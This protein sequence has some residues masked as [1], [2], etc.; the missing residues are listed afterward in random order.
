M[1]KNSDNLYSLESLRSMANGDE[2]F[3]KEMVVLFLN[4]APETINLIE[5]SF[6]I[7]NFESIADQAHK[8]KSTLQIIGNAKVHKLVKEIESQALVK[9]T[10][11]LELSIDKLKLQMSQLVDYL[12]KQI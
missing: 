9:S 8:L 12:K 1:K 10:E 11:Q 3:V 4:K 2:V 7:K 5:K 6:E